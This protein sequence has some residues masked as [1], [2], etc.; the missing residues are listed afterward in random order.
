MF[1]DVD[2][3]GF[4]ADFR[5]V[6]NTTLQGVDALIVV[7]GPN[8]ELDRLRQPNDYVRMEIL[9]AL[10]LGKGIV[11]VLVDEA[12]MPGPDQLPADLESFA[13][14]NAAPLRAD[15]DFDTDAARLV[16][17]LRRSLQA[18]AGR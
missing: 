12:S 5:D 1:Y 17:D 4:G 13:Y 7:V 16:R 10:R 11:P 18:D 15:P 14:R 8:F 6:I 2:S 9:E 3:V